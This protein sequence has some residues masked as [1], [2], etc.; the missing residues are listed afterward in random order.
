M[1]DLERLLTFL[2]DFQSK[3]L[4]STYA[5]FAEIPKYSGTCEFFFG[6]VYS[7]EDPTER[8]REFERFYHRLKVVFAGDIERCMRNMIELQSL[9]CE[10]D[11]ALLDP[12]RQLGADRSFD[13]STYERA[14]YLCDNYDQRRHQI[15]LLVETL[16]LAHH[17]YHLPAIGIAL[18][19]LHRVHVWMGQT[20]ITEFLLDGYHQIRPVKDIGPLAEAIGE[21]ELSR[22]DRI[23]REQGVT[24]ELSG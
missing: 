19:T 4:R 13:L 24:A 21:R 1:D 7:S 14:Y 2:R 12:L 5:D 6:R 20:M 17:L 15:D 23:W 18:R 9:S 22:L 8:D 11:Q 10:L 3:R 16:R